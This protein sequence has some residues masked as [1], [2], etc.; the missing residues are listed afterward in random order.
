MTT[1]QTL[2]RNVLKSGLLS[3][4]QMPNIIPLVN[5]IRVLNRA[6]VSY[7]L[8]GAHGLASW[9]GKPRATED[10]DVVVATRHLKKAVDALS[11]AF[12]NLEAED[13][14]VVIR[15]RDRASQDVL[16]DVMKPNQQPYR[17]VFKNDRTIKVEEQ[18]VRI[19][20]LEMALVMK[21]SAMVSLHRA[22]KDKFQDAHDFIYIVE[23]N[24]NVDKE[25]LAELAELIFDGAGK[26]ILETVRRIEAGEKLVL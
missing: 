24:P 22:D 21:Y 20:S 15:L 13:C 7:V 26:E 25:K 2:E 18:K 19:P 4:S 17:E 3:H 1:G 10:V 11:K 16:I 12:P 14:A 5:V 23:N 6:K 8:V 9:R